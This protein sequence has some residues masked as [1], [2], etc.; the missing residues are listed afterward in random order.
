M[1]I[2]ELHTRKRKTNLAILLVIL[3][4]CA[5]VFGISIVKMQVQSPPKPTEA[6]VGIDNFVQNNTAEPPATP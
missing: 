4:F 1:P 5:L 2:E 3:G 6:V